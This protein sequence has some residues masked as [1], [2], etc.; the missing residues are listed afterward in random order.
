M[1]Q[2]TVDPQPSRWP[3]R[4]VQAMG[5][6]AVPDE[7]GTS[8]WAGALQRMRRNPTAILGAVIVLGFV[9]V[10]LLAPVL[11]PYEPASTE[12]IAMVTPSDVPGPFPGHP[13]GLDPFGSDLLTQLLY[14]ARQSLII[15]VVSTGLGLLVG[16]LLGG[17]AGAFGGWVDTVVMRVVD[18]LLS[19]PS[20]LLAVSVAAVL[21][22]NPLAIMIAIAAAQ[23]PI[24][25]RL[26]RGSML[27]QR[28]QDYVLAASSLGLRRRTVVMS[29]VLPNSLGPVIVQATLTLATSIIEVAALSYLGLGAPNPAVAE[30]GR[31]LVK[32]QERLQSEPHLTL[33]PGLCI[34]V[35]A[36]GFTLFG[37]ALREALD[38]KAR[39]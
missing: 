11:A 29:H 32:G 34:A 2:P 26:L 16:A 21:G 6:D 14:G 38:P 15:G 3:P 8:L 9:L 1:S 19:I 7:K 31:M 22:R 20:L 4:L 13:L 35:T 27:A 10:A 17:V 37:E 33:L 25:A 36:L 23:V 24:F 39:R 18:I 12:W 5:G 28:G 30:W